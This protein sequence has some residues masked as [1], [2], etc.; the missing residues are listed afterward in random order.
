MRCRLHGWPGYPVLVVACLAALLLSAACGGGRPQVEPLDHSVLRLASFDFPENRMLAELYGQQLRAAGFRVEVLAG[1]GTRE[2]VEPA[3]EQGLV[4]LVIDYTGSLLD[5]AGGSAAQTHGTP[6][7]VH[8]TLAASLSG[9]GL[10]ALRYAPAEDTNGFAVRAAFA[11]ENQLTRL[12]DLRGLAGRLTF[13]GP[14][15]CPQRRY[16]LQGLRTAYGLSFRAFRPLSTRDATAT[17]LE[18]GE[19]DV[20]MLETTYG[21]LGERRVTLLIDDLS[22][23]PRENVVPVVRT[24][25]LRRYGARLTDALDGLSARLDATDLVKLNRSGAVDARN[26]ADV[27]AAYL[28]RLTG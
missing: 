17:A 14:P 3:L 6:D 9:R 16:C 28:S 8:A 13:G 19:I 21:R 1:L 12:S 20:G 18:T 23:Q 25:V 7:A 5:Y 10:S 24:D 11:R 27:A 26:P 15:E 22:L 2:V 4:D